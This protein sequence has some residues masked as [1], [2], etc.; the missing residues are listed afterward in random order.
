MGTLLVESARSHTAR[1][2]NILGVSI[3]AIDMEQA[4][5]QAEALIDTH[6]KGYI[7]VTGVHGIMEAVADSELREILNHS[8]LAVPDGM[9]TV[10][11]GR[12]YG[13]RKMRRVYGPDFMLA[14]CDRSRG[15]GYRHFFYGGSPGVAEELK[16]RLTGLYP[17]LQVVGTYTPPF[18]PLTGGET[19]ALRHEVARARPDIVW[20]GLSTPKQERFMHAALAGLDTRLMVGVG[21]AFDIHTGRIIDAPRW[22]KQ[23]GLQWLHR[24]IQEPRRLA[25]RYLVNNPIFLARICGQ[26]LDDCR[27]GRL[28]LRR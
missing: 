17:G 15:K 9:P 23:T 18:R 24:L 25:R 11:I 2:V 21:A 16:R 14:L 22:M 3:S 12:L 4:L 6:G 26:L 5:D 13:H 10:W 1:S 28:R 20:V 27:T 19:E 7:C 8:F